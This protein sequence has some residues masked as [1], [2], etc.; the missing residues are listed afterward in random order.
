M[1]VNQ[2][3]SADQFFLMPDPPNGAK[4][5][6]VRGEVVTMTGP[7]FL[8][9]LTCSKIDRRIGRFVDEHD[10]GWIVTN[11][12][13]VITERDPD[14]V[15]GADVAFWRKDRI[16]EP[17][18]GYPPVP[19]DLAVEVL[20]PSNTRK[21]I[22]EKFEEYFACGV[23]MVW[24]VAPE[25]RTVTIYQTPD[26]GLVLHDSKN[27]KVHGGDVLPGFECRVADLLP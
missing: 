20:S 9:G 6:L 17:M 16:K 7:G 27:A 5:E 10:I 26:Q 13:G 18:V 23:R 11:D 22:R 2:L 19:P 4:Q 24:V 3:I 1:A 25:D 12:T 14:T 21:E 8:H 15:R